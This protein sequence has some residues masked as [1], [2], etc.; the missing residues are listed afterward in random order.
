MIWAEFE[1]RLD[2]MNHKN[3]TGSRTGDIIVIMNA[4]DGYMAVNH[5]GD[6]LNGWHGGPTEGESYV[7]MMFNM[8]GEGIIP[9]QGKTNP[10]FV[11]DSLDEHI[12]ELG[13]QEHF[14]VWQMGPIIQ[15][16]MQEVRGGTAP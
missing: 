9:A 10:A 13:T 15:S 3:A 7:P 8:P 11:Q 16:M 1:E 4:E 6:M 12:A 5:G 2:E 14:R